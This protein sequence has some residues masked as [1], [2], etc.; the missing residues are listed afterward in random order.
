MGCA[1]CI[2]QAGSVGRA[3]GPPGIAGFA[4]G[5]AENRRLTGADSDESDFRIRVH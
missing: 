5:M 3:A 1:H 4:P 2:T